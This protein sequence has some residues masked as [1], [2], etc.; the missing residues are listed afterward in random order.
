MNII[1]KFSSAKLSYKFNYLFMNSG[2]FQLEQ[3]SLY[4]VKNVGER[5]KPTL[6]IRV[7]FGS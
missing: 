3:Y 7:E 4:C 5:R 1:Y 2:L 6:T